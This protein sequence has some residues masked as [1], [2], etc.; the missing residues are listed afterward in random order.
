MKKLALIVGV[1]AFTFTSCKKTFTCE[2]D[3]TA[4][5]KGIE[6]YEIEAK[7]REEA[8]ATCSGYADNTG[9]SVICKLK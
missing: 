6:T 7:D 2:C 3:G 9:G 5:G 8:E 4:A 1:L